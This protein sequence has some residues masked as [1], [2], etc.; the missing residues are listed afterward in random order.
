MKDL[1]DLQHRL[2]QLQSSNQASGG[3]SDHTTAKGS[4]AKSMQ[5]RLRA[6]NGGDGQRGGAKTEAGYNDRLAKLAAST[7]DEVHRTKAASLEELGDR[8]DRLGPSDVPHVG[9]DV[10]EV[11]ASDMSIFR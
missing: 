6:L 3:R 8:L 11:R 9:Y 4:A 1:D 5:E 10:P 2:K 7:E